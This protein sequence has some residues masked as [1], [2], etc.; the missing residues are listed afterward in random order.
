VILRSNNG[1]SLRPTTVTFDKVTAV[2]LARVRRS[3]TDAATAAGLS[4]DRADKYTLAVN[5]I[6]INAI[7]HG[8]GAAT[9][10]I[11]KDGRRVVVE[12]CD[13]GPGLSP[14]QDGARPSPEDLHGRGIW[15]ARQLT[16]RVEIGSTPTGARIRL[17]AIAAS[18]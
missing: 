17:T 18:S 16:D 6:V 3:V 8:G 2:D 7:Q 4:E 10:T 11:M 5:E 1:S 15:L 14:P 12:V 13:A 9:V